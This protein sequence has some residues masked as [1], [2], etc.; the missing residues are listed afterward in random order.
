MKI[1]GE[2]P[3]PRSGHSATLVGSYLYIFGGSNQHGILS[4]IHRLNLANVNLY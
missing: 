1:L 2:P 4:D 3:S